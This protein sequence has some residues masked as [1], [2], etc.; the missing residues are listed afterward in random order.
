MS[1]YWFDAFQ[2]RQLKW[3]KKAGGCIATIDPLKNYWLIYKK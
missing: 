3:I 2:F 1:G